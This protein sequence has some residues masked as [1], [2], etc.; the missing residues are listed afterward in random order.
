MPGRF[1]ATELAKAKPKQEVSTDVKP[2][3]RIKENTKTASYTGVIVLGVAVT[4]ALFYAIFRELF[5]SSS[6]NSVYSA[7]L[8][9]CVND[10]RVQDAL[11]APIKGF[12]EE[13][14]RRRR[15]HVAHTNY[16]KDGVKFMRM[17]FY[18]QGIRNKGTVFLEMQEVR[19]ELK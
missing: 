18:I 4:G 10:P 19:R 9:K 13:N 7:A 14:S 11:G 3:E 6:S 12:G 8:D 1:Y 5:S 17:N 16:E 15:R 2:M